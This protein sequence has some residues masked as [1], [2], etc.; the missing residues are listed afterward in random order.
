V[1]LNRVVI[2]GCGVVSPVGSDVDA[3]WQAL[4]AGRCGLKKLEDDHLPDLR[5]RVYGPVSGYHDDDYFEPLAARKIDHFIRYG[6][7][8]AEQAVKSSGLTEVPNQN[9]ERIGVAIGSGI[10]GLSSI[11]E[12]FLRAQARGPGRISPHFIPATI[13]NMVAGHVS[14]RYGFQGPNISV[15]TACATGT[16]NIGLA[17]QSIASGATDAMVAGG[18]EYASVMLGLAGFAAMK[19]LSRETD[20]LRASRPFDVGRDGFVLSDGAGVLVL[21]SYE[22]ARARGAPILAEIVGF[23]MT[24]DAYHVTQPAPGGVG[25]IRAMEQAIKMGGCAL[26]QIDYINAHGTSTLY[27]DRTEGH[28]IQTLFGDHAQKL[29]VSSTKSML[30]HML[31]AAGSVE[32][33]ICALALRDQRVPPTINCDE[34]EPGLFLDF[35]REGAREHALTYALSNSFGFGGNNATLLLKRME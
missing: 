27:N 21:E 9:L 31:G 34:V 22:Y 18:A 17:Y 1:Q 20:P 35:V 28:A 32:A 8:A 13:I 16:H 10:G 30:G 14:M 23:G 26:N 33:V 3:C 6:V 12:N 5:A 19:A 7:A 29:L 24:A 15:V 25:A 11:E 2:T 4:L